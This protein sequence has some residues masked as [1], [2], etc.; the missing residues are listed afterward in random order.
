MINPGLTS[1]AAFNSTRHP[2]GGHGEIT[3]THWLLT[4]WNG[5]L[6]PQNVQLDTNTPPGAQK[7][8]RGPHV[9]IAIFPGQGA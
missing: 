2:V 1:A 9:P 8:G 5:E 4:H 3:K 6:Q 7:L